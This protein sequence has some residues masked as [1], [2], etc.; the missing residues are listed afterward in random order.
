MYNKT[1]I[2]K[3]LIQDYGVKNTKDIQDMLKDL[4]A[5]TIQEMLEAELEDHLGYERYDNQNKST[6]NSRNGYRSKRVKSDFGEVK[7]N[8]P[9]DR[10]GNFQPRV[11]QNYEND[12]SGIEDQVIGMYSKGMSTR[13]ISSHLKSIYG[14]DISHTLVS[15]ITDR[16]LPLANEWQNRP[17]DSIYPIVFMDAVHY[18]VRIDGRIINKAAYAAIGINLEGTKEVLGIWVGENESSKYWLKVLTEIRNRGVKDILIAS[19]DGLSGFSEAIKAVFPDTEIQRCIV[20]QIR[21]T[22]GYV[23]YKHRKEFAKDLKN[24]YTALNEEVALNELTLLE[25]KW[26]DK[27]EIALRSWR[28]NWNELSTYFKY[29]QEI[30]TLIYTTN[31]MESYNRQLRKVTKSKSIFPSDNSL[32]KSLYLATIDISDKWTQKVRNWSQ[33]LAHLSIY[34]E[35]RITSSIY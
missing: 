23:S 4:F 26:N 35:E 19:V 28:N 22:L 2:L 8:I 3:Y 15:K 24:V 13:D 16:V 11:I 27:Y 17:L 10:N 34:F 14:V 9:R 7:L 32:H 33:I 20:H 21:N 25:E 12:I 1:E 31:S 6:S 29:P 5:S 18:K 30:R